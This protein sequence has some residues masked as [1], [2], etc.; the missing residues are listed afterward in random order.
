MSASSITPTK[1]AALRSHIEGKKLAAAALPKDPNVHDGTVPPPMPESQP[2]QTGAPPNSRPQNPTEIDMNK[3]GNPPLDNNPQGGSTNAAPPAQVIDEHNQKAASILAKLS[4]FANQLGSTAGAA[5]VPTKAASQNA[6]PAAQPTATAPVPTEAETAEAV[7]LAF[8]NIGAALLQDEEGVAAVTE[9]LT[10]RAG[11]EKAMAMM[12]NAET[13]AQ[14]AMVQQL[15]EME[16]VAAITQYQQEVAQQNAAFQQTLA[17]MSP[18]EQAR[19]TKFA[20]IL[21]HE[22][23]LFQHPDDAYWFVKGAAAMQA[24]LDAAGGQMPEGPLPGG[25]EGNP[26]PEDII[27]MIIQ[28]LQAGEIGPEEAIQMAQEAGVELPP[29]IIAQ[30]QAAPEEEAAKQASVGLYA[31]LG[32]DTLPSVA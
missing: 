31:A 15:E 30:L 10:K 18:A 19:T 16:K 23:Q 1:L 13:A 32:V 17:S 14:I 3:G 20:S 25:E 8:A 11:A 9:L 22:A 4:N 2:D 28:A 12:Q 7:K 26:A 27:A 5:A 29:E 24:G 21:D 6:A